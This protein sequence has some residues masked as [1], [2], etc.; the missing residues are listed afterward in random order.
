MATEIEFVGVGTPSATDGGSNPTPALSGSE[1]DDDLMILAVYSREGVDGSIADPSGWT[2]IYHDLG[3]SGLIGLWYRY[4]VTADSAPAV[5]LSNHASGDTVIA[6]VATWR[7]VKAG[8][9]Y[10]VGTMSPNTSQA[11]IGPI[12]GVALPRKGLVLVFGGRQDDWTSVAV[13]SGEDLNWQEVDETD[14]TL[15]NDAGSVLDYAIN[16]FLDIIV[17]SKTFDVTGGAANYGKGV[18]LSF[19]LDADTFSASDDIIPYCAQ[20][21]PTGDGGAPGGEINL[22][23]R[24]VFTDLAANDEVEIVSDSASDTTQSCTIKGR[25]SSGDLVQETATITGTTPVVFSTMGAI[26][27]IE[28]VELSGPC[29]GVVTVRRDGAAGDIGDIPA[30]EIGFRRIF[31]YAYPHPT[32]AK[33][34]YEKIFIKNNHPTETL[35]NAVVS[36]NADPEAQVAFTLD[37]AVNDDSFATNRLT[38]PSSSDTDPDTFDGTDKNVPGLNLDPG[39]AIGVWLEMTVPAADTLFFSSYSLDLDYDLAS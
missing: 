3:T 36:E 9:P 13:L 31:A 8:G 19:E 23:M 11:D 12:S 6:R 7:G 27:N 38:T 37:A 35:Q 24:A 17:S 2:R 33:T 18:M 10:A 1:Q 29:L 30:G 5:A 21:H 22:L 4:F 34:Y 32:S 28:S 26:D 20:S 15:G 25:D 39:D 14:S 16:P